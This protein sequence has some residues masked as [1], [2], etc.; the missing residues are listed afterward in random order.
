M[1]LSAR[2]LFLL[3]RREAKG[4]R[5]EKAAGRKKEPIPPRE[6]GRTRNQNSEHR[7]G[8]LKDTFLPL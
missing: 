5:D 8:D 1:H 7:N 6:R 4:G 3:R 2:F